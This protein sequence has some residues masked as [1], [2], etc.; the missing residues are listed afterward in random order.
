MQSKDEM[1]A[2]LLE[3]TKKR[4]QAELSDLI[5]LLY[6]SAFGCGHFAPG[7][8]QVTSYL[9][10]ELENTQADPKG[11]MIEPILGRFVRVNIAPYAA[12]GMRLETLSRLFMLTADHAPGEEAK[13]WFNDALNLLQE[14][15]LGGELPF[16]AVSAKERL[17]QYRAAGCPSVH[18]SETFR[19][20][21]H[22]AYR[23]LRSDYAQLLPVFSQIDALLEGRERVILAIDGNSGAG[24][25]T[26]A[27]LLAAVYDDALLVHMDDFFLQL[28][29]RTKERFDTPG[30]NVDH[31]R[32]LSE[33]LEPMQRGEAFCYRPFDCARMTIGEGRMIAPER[34]SIVEG[35]Y[36]LH[37]QLEAAYDVTIVLRISP[38]AQAERILQR[39]G[40]Q[41]LGR[42]M[43]E[44][45]PMENRYFETTGI[46]DRCDWIIRV[47][48]E[49]GGVG[50]AV[51]RTEE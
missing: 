29:Q 37:P 33:V 17:S 31:E 23:I 11:E 49:K 21:Y 41:M 25:S 32:F 10:Q 51:C 20:A 16:S 43:N 38:A 6:Q 47:T 48:P 5:K 28:H 26:L 15:A 35:S 9:R 8:A 50:Y 45:I 34:L 2:F 12:Q 42:F 39:N 7:Q 13:A 19:A 22:P 1:R 36:S 3:Y 40:A 30:G 4:P 46:E 24:K 18:H 44:W 14:M 27:N